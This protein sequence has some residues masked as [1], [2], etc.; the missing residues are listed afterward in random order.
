MHGLRLALQ[1]IGDTCW[2]QS[3]HRHAMTKWFHFLWISDFPAVHVVYKVYSDMWIVHYFYIIIF[4]RTVA[5]MLSPCSEG[6]HAQW[7][8]L[9]R[10]QKLS[11]LSLA[12]N[13][14][15]QTTV[16][17]NS[18]FRVWFMHVPSC[19]L[20]SNSFPWFRLAMAVCLWVQVRNLPTASVWR[21][22]KPSHQMRSLLTSLPTAK[23]YKL[24]NKT[25]TTTAEVNSSIYIL[26]YC[27]ASTG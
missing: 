7:V 4:H 15:M 12:V 10:H 21:V 11:C 5:L 13:D 23:S 2:L 20:L 22:I 8:L 9:T 1:Q 25:S 26:I 6:R 19:L 18:A 16:S 14:K 27:Q 3:P 24:A 17:L